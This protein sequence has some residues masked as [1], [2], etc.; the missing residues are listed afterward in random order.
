MGNP[1]NFLNNRY[2]VIQSLGGGGYS[3][4]FLAEDTHL[5]SNRRCVI[6]QLKPVST[7][8]ETHRVVQER[9]QREA[10]ILETL[11]K[12]HEQIPE[13]FAYFTEGNQ[14]F[15]VEEW[16]E[17]KTLTQLVRQNGPFTEAAIRDLLVSIL[18]V[19][20][21][22]HTRRIIHRDIKPDNII[23]RNSDGKP[24][25]IDFGVVKEVIDLDSLGNPTSTIMI[26]TKGFMPLEQAAGKPVYSSDLYGLGMTSI[27]LLAGRTPKDL[28]DPETG[29]MIWRFYA[30]GVSPQMAAILDKSIAQLPRDRFATARDM[31]QALLNESEKSSV[32]LPALEPKIPF[33][34][35]DSNLRSFSFR[36]V[37]V[38]ESGNVI[39]STYGQANAYIEELTDSVQFEMVEVPGGAFLM[40]SDDVEIDRVLVEYERSGVPSIGASKQLRSESPQHQVTV[41]PFFIGKFQVTQAQW[42]AVAALSKVRIELNPDPSFFKGDSRPVEQVSW[43]EAQEFCLRLSKR[44]GRDYQLPSEAQWE[45]ACRAGTT[46]PFSFGDTITSDL[47]NYE[48]N[49]PYANAPKGLDRK[50]TV[51]VGSIGFANPFGLFDMHGNVWEWCM[52]VWHFNYARAPIDGSVWETGGDPQFRVVRGGSWNSFGH[53][54]RSALRFRN[55]PLNRYN[56]LG[57]R[58]MHLPGK[59]AVTAN[60]FPTP[61][62]GRLS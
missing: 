56:N 26:G 49:F 17:G 48:A 45:Y 14:F 24:V 34:G 29:E 2:R 13:L 18:P 3:H 54:C 53:L 5:P 44:T 60:I 57:F 8:P 33:S 10:V 36:V 52:D 43:E 6:K 42:K 15:M 55:V 1:Q 11:G 35:S 62:L 31:L 46:T 4:T 58:V 20:D 47:V 23:I 39:D 7:D 37:K 12:G 32:S 51:P 19:L 22:V 9:F 59:A 16:V 38:D 27:C 50:Q 21:Y 41:S 25:L 28:V 40:G 61:L 30:R